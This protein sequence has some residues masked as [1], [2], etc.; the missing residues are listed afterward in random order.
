LSQLR[1]W[2]S[3][4]VQWWGQRGRWPRLLPTSVQASSLVPYFK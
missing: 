2:A 3:S 4:L 1:R